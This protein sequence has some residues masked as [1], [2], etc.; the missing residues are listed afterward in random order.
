MD[1]PRLAPFGLFTPEGYLTPG[2][3]DHYLFFPGRDDVHGILLALLVAETMGLKL[4]M[5]GYDDDALNAAILALMANPNVAVQGTLDSS[6]A[7]GVHERAILASD[8]ANNPDFYNSFVVT[9]SATRQISHTK[10]GA[11]IAQGLWFEG[12]TNWSNAGEGTGIQLDPHA[13]PAPGYK[14]QNNTLLVSANPVGLAR[15]SARLDV[16]HLTGLAHRAA[17]A[18]AAAAKTAA[19]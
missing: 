7:G 8:L 9:T 14:A 10:G 4:N 13:I 15:F 1:D 17:A 18:A 2:Y 5:F 3:G 16:E 12:S 6:Q 11:L 19:G